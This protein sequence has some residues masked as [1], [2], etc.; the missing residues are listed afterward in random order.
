MKPGFFTNEHLAALPY[1]ARL[2]FAGLWTIAD[3]EGRLEDRPLR[4]KAVLFPYDDLDMNGLLAQ[5]EQ[6]GFIVRY[7]ADGVAYVAI[8]TFLEHQRPKS[9]ETPSAIPAPILA[10]P[11]GKVSAPRPYNGQR[12]EG[13]GQGTEGEDGADGA[14]L[15]VADGATQAE[16]ADV[17][18]RRCADDLMALWNER[19]HP[20]IH[21]G[22]D[23]TSK[24]RRQIRSRLT[25]RSVDEWG[26]VFDRIQAS[27]FCCGANDRGWV[28]S[29]DWVIGSPDVA[30]KVIEGKYDE[31]RKAP[32][33]EGGGGSVCQHEPRCAS[34]SVCT[35]RTLAD[36]RAARLAR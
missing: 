30:V 16:P 9:D 26:A 14:P 29:F 25:E 20:P 17:A 22:R 34:W 18:A 32:R 31:R 2:C 6:K 15:L 23:L 8:P 7:I 5:L 35:Q 4:I 13:S 10:D 1:E 36:G 11:R 19:T 27:P 3:R 33:A 21:R 24:R 12:T 28:A